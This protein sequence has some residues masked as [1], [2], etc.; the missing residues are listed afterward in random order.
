MIWCET[1]PIP[2]G[3]KGRV[4]GDA[5]RYNEAA[6]NLM[7]QLGDIHVNKL[8][9]FAEQHGK[10]REANVHYTTAGS[11]ALA[12]QVA[13]VIRAAVHDRSSHYFVGR[14]GITGRPTRIDPIGKLK[15]AY[16]A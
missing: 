13:K 16:I 1:R 7:D 2:K 6:A 3:S 10:Q 4:P 15:P 12:E 14:S 8:Y 5:A 11:A 9:G